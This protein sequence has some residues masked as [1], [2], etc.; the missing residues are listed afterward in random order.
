MKIIISREYSM[1][2]TMVTLDDH[3]TAGWDGQSA[4]MF[5]SS[6]AQWARRSS[7]EGRFVRGRAIN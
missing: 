3:F 5:I 6:D 7:F 1:A 2:M 4:T